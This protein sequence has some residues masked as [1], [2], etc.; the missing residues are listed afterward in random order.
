MP[1]ERSRSRKICG[2]YALVLYVARGQT[3]RIGKLGAF[4]FPRGYY[5]YV[6]SALN[7]L[8]ARLARHLRPDKK[9]FW[10]IDY[11]LER[12]TI[13]QVWTHQGAERLECVWARAA[14]A[15]PRARIIA[16]R[17]GASDCACPAHLIYFG[18]A[19]PKFGR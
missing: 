5:I 18:A 6:G 11:L 7:G 10:H 4:K 15:L 2:T 14:L 12:A 13:K 1:D 3:I 9:R 16:P 8:S 17:F 19:L